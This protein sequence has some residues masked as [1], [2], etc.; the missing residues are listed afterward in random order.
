MPSSSCSLLEQI[1]SNHPSHGRKFSANY[2][3]RLREKW[4][5]RLKRLSYLTKNL[6]HH[7]RTRST[8]PSPDHV[9]YRVQ[10]SPPPPVEE[11]TSRIYD[12]TALGEPMAVGKDKKKVCW[13]ALNLDVTSRR[14]MLHHVHHTDSVASR[15]LHQVI[16]DVTSDRGLKPMSPFSLGF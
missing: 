16:M 13:Y 7:R 5:R 10:I 6:H 9:Y 8:A 4:L 14:W 3:R 15:A 1:K 2:L 12:A 11:I